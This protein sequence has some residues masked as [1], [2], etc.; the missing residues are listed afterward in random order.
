MRPACSECSVQ[1]AL[2][3]H[4]PVLHACLHDRACAQ[5]CR[6]TESVQFCKDRWMTPVPISSNE[7]AIALVGLAGSQTVYTGV[8]RDCVGDGIYCMK[9]GKACITNSFGCE[10]LPKN[11]KYLD[12]R[13][14]PEVVPEAEFADQGPYRY[15]P[16][17][18][19]PGS[20]LNP[21][22][23]YGAK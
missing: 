7:E 19:T 11:F 17:I 10:S 20:M 15:A 12:G 21:R 5:H 18:A 6:F 22:F 13:D 3:A 23:V 9:D 1:L 8:E 4:A 14:Y 2:N 16:D